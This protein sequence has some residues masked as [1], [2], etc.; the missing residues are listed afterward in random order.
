MRIVVVIYTVVWMKPI[1]VFNLLCFH[2]KLKNCLYNIRLY[3][4]SF[5]K[6][7]L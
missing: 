5:D 7:N 4:L 6:R 2:N 3:L 1:F